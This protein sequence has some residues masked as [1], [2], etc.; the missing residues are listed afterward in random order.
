MHPVKA[1]VCPIVPLGDF[2]LTMS[3]TMSQL[4]R[5]KQF[6]T[7]VVSGFHLIIV[8]CLTQSSLHDC[9]ALLA[10]EVSLELNEVM[11][12]NEEVMYTLESLISQGI[13]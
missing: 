5:I 6:A 11:F 3:P 1:T 13:Y 12:A 7:T 10:T 8:S 4:N 2:I 9:V